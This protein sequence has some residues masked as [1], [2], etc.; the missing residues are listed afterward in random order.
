MTITN[1][2]FIPKTNLKFDPWQQTF[3]D[4]AEIFKGGWPWTPETKAEWLLLMTTSGKKKMRFD[5]VWAKV[6]S[7]L[8]DH[9]DEQEL[10]DARK[11]YESGDK[12]NPAD[13]SI[14]MFINRHMRYE[15]LVTNQQ[16]IAMG[17]IVPDEIKTPTYDSNADISGN[18]LASKVVRMK[19]LIHTSSV[20]YAI[21]GSKAKGPGVDEIE[22]FLAIT[23]ADVLTPP[24]LSEFKYDG[25]VKRGLYTRTFDASLEGKRA[26]YYAR[27][28][29]KGKTI[30]FGPPSDFW[31]AVIP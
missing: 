11:D 20:V 10:K 7:K 30:T 16:K 14:R 1:K 28:R 2:D 31:H 15:P 9:S 18:E 12:L 4:Q 3:F 6:K 22:V 23:A 26:W 19:H 29:I 8:F 25:V 24:A 21:S 5:A 27:L 13:T 17:L